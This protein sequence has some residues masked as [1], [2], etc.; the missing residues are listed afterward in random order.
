MPNFD[1][2]ATV[3]IGQRGD[4]G[5]L[6][7]DLRVVFDIT[8]SGEAIPNA[9]TIGIYNL[10]KFSRDKIRN[11]GDSIELEAG[12]RQ[13]EYGGRLVI[14]ADIVDIVTE[15]AGPDLVTL[16]R[17]GDGV[18]FLK[19]IK[20][21]YSFKEGASVKDIIAK[22]TGGEGITL[23]SLEGVVDAAFANGFSEMGPLGEILDKVVGKLGATWSFQNNELQILPKL[24]SNDSP[25]FL[26]SAQTGM[27]GV[28]TRD[29]DTTNITPAPQSAGWKVTAQLRPELGPGDRVE[30]VSKVTEASG[31]YHIKEVK[32]SGDSYQG[33]WSST[34]RLRESSNG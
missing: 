5:F 23:K 9:G 10:A 33:D 25:I 2:F 13:D 15:R 8:K 11:I 16:V 18:E 4:K 12:H 27:L 26:L 20:R 24:G 32:H 3:R 29:V 17:L 31:L 28:P 7:E 30:V 6:I 22:I 34:L 1:R 14:T 19:N 21:S